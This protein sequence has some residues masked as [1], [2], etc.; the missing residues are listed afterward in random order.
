MAK[1]EID[2]EATSVQSEKLNALADY[3]LQNES[4][5]GAQFANLMEG[6][7]LGEASATSLTDGFEEA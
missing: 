2:N 7:E 1:K 6:R 3:L 4:I 5:T